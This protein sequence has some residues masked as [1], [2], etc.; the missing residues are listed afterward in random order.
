ML[1]IIRKLLQQTIDRID[2][3]NSN[4]TDEEGK[5]IIDLLND[6]TEPKISKYQAC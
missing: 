1:N 2:A 4:I 3:G 5:Q 6:I